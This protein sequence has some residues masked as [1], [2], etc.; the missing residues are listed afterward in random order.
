MGDL[1]RISWTDHTFNPWTGCQ[2]VSH[3]CDHCYA[4]AWAKRVGRDLFGGRSKRKRT[5]KTIWER[6]RLWN[7]IAS[8]KRKP[9]KVFCASLADVFEDAPGPNEWRVDVWDLIRETPWLDW[10]LLTKRPEN[11][12]AMLPDDWGDGWPHVWLGTSIGIRNHVDRAD[13]L[14][15]V[16]AKVRFISAEP[17]IGPLVPS[18]ADYRAELGDYG[19]EHP[20]GDWFWPDG[21]LVDEDN[22]P[23]DLTAIDWLIAGGESGAGHRPMELGWAEDLRQACRSSICP[24]CAGLGTECPGYAAGCPRCGDRRTETA[25][26]FKQISAH[27]NEQGEDA[28]GEVLHEFPARWDR[29]EWPTGQGSDS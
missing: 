6:P 5:V 26:F 28:L 4:E 2:K 12:A 7:R 23:L 29:L 17:L 8:E 9:R 20:S 18:P 3:E 16:P 27:R 10:Q 25:F 24:L 19:Q 22:P 14:R 13:I 11:I 15:Q 1:T 21:D